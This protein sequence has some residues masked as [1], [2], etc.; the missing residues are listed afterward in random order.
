M[1]CNYLKMRGME[2]WAKRLRDL[3]DARVGSIEELCRQ[4]S[5]DAEERPLNRNQVTRYLSGEV[6]NP[7]L[8]TLRRIARPLG[9]RAADILPD[10]DRSAP[11]PAG[12][13]TSEEEGW[14]VLWR[15]LPETARH[16][17]AEVATLA[18]KG[19]AAERKV[20]KKKPGRRKAN[21]RRP[22]G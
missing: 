22:R 17:L 14:L 2:A 3:I 1:T 6:R 10:R 9:L 20:G 7:G 15:G 18:A 11:V 12:S 16:A 5:D 21:A 8:V 4:A 13:L 19:A